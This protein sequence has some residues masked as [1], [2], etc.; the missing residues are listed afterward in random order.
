MEALVL[1]TKGCSTTRLLQSR[2]AMALL[3]MTL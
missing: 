1:S 2:G 3:E